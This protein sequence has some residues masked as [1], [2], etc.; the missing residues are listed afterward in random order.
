MAYWGRY[1]GS[2]QKTV[3]TSRNVALGQLFSSVIPQDH[4]GHYHVLLLKGE[5]LLVIPLAPV[6]CTYEP[7]LHTAY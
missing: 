1:I 2:M 4:V 7:V 5:L 3:L 6:N